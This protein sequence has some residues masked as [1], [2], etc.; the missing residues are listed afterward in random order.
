[1]EA[2]G[3]IAPAGTVQDTAPGAKAEPRRIYSTRELFRRA[4]EPGPYHNFPGSF[5]EQIFQ[6]T[7]TVTPNYWRVPKAGLSND[8][9]LYTQRGSINGRPGTFEIGV[10]PSVSG[11]V[12]II[13]HRFF[14]HD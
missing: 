8:G 9:V 7:R 13:F 5:D 4:E 3:W 2:T 10:R 6:G 12:E 1:M 14:R 11:A